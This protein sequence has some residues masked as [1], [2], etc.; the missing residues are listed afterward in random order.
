MLTFLSCEELGCAVSVFVHKVYSSVDRVLEC[1][2]FACAWQAASLLPDHGLDLCFLHG[3]GVQ[4][5]SHWTV[6]PQCCVSWPPLSPLA[7]DRLQRLFDAGRR[8]LSW[9]S[10]CWTPLCS[11]LEEVV[12]PL[13][14]FG[15]LWITPFLMESCCFWA[16]QV[17]ELLMVVVCLTSHQVVRGEQWARCMSRQLAHTTHQ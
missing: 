17:M 5:P 8:C 7:G 2:S 1:F 12:L 14:C 13:C 3:E 15:P 4:S 10:W 6:E 11:S 16:D 9:P